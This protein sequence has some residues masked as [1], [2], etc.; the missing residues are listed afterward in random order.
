MIDAYVI[1]L[2]RE[3]DKKARFLDQSKDAELNFIFVNA[4]DGNDL[5]SETFS[6]APL[7]YDR[8]LGTG[9]TRGEI[10]CAL[11]HYKA[12]EAFYNSG[13]IHAF[14]FE[15]DVYFKGNTD[16]AL[17]YPP[18]ADIVYVLR[19]PLKA[20]KEYNNYF[21]KI[22]ASYWLCGYLLTR[23]GVEKLLLTNYKENL[24]V[25]DEFLPLLY[26]REYLSEYN[27]YYNGI[28]LKAYA[29][30]KEYSFIDLV[31]N[32]FKQSTTYHSP[33]YEY[34][35]EFVCLVQKGTSITSLQRFQ[36]SCRKY[37]VQCRVVDDIAAAVETM[38]PEKYV[39][40]ANPDH[41]FFINHPAKY[42]Q[43]Q[44]VI[45]SVEYLTGADSMSITDKHSMLLNGADNPLLL[46]K[47]E[48]Y[49]VSKVKGSYGCVL[50]RKDTYTDRVC[51][52]VLAYGSYYAC[53]QSVCSIDYPKNLLDVV[54]YTDMEFEWDSVQ[55]YKATKLEA[56]YNLYKHLEDY[57]YIWVVDSS[58]VFTEP[59]ILKDCIDSQKMVVSGLV[60][61]TDTILSN[62]WGEL[63]ENGWYRRS[64]D[65]FTI[66][67][68]SIE[69]V[70][71][72]PFVGGNVLIHRNMFEYDLYADKTFKDPDMMLCHNLRLLNEGMYLINL[73]RY[74]YIQQ[75]K[76]ISEWGEE[77][78][79]DKEYLSFYREGTDIFQEVKKDTDIWFFPFFKP[80]FCNYLVEMAERNGQWSGGVY[81]PQGSVDNRI[82]AVENIPTQDIHL[83]DLGLD[84]FW[85]GI[86]KQHF[87]KVMSHLYKY[88]VKN[89]NIAFI[90]KYDA[91]RGQ[92]SL[93]PHHD[94]SV[95]TTNIAL[96]NCTDYE[97]GKVL[98]HSKN[99]EFINRNKGY[100]CLH[101]GRI[102]H[103][104][105]AFPIT[106]GKRYILV[107]FNN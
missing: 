69:N 86:V 87:K 107:S 9:I 82:N 103:Y 55:I 7:W 95:Y 34:D 51:A 16:L 88:L 21:D 72:V 99:V 52:V 62:F 48:N 27:N 71:N 54:V 10:G 33:Y 26:D 36:Q 30:K 57:E 46:N 3:T 70:W 76:P 39:I 1:H 85:N 20:D 98:F 89:Y 96:S 4:V 49:T 73:K 28:Q 6:I 58:N 59:S 105:E 77:E 61:K 29:I 42:I 94:A 66:L 19:K 68:R 11:S 104:H 83:K 12:W 106:K 22:Q 100:V 45:E 14:F 64:D 56:Y 17:T 24:I 44:K 65:Y 93:Q 32:T 31:P 60:T 91:N 75:Y 74:G 63:D 97:G 13:Q 67:N 92:T 79:F 43:E 84:D 8:Y 40:I 15:D 37:S 47:Y 81:A 78:I 50:S 25:V 35:S 5:S 2:E 38:D 90:V 53:L 102:T 18:Y 101:P 23:R 80:E 41:C